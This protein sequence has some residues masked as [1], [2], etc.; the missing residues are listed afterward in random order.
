MDRKLTN[1]TAVASRGRI[2]RD[3]PQR[4]WATLRI[5][6]AE[7]AISVPELWRLAVSG[8]VKASH[9]VK[10]GKTRGT[11]LINCQSLEQYIESFGPGSSRRRSARDRIRRRAVQAREVRSG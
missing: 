10:P 8:E 11:W 9:R 3:F 1:Q 7:Y 4:Q 2:S 5:A 6:S